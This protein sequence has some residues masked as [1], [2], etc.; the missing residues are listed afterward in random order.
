LSRIES[1]QKENKVMSSNAVS[2][3]SQH[4]PASQ[5]RS[6][7]A[8]SISQES[9]GS[10]YVPLVGRVLFSAL[11]LMA[12]PGHFTRQEIG[13]AA[14]QHV[15]LA[16]LLVPFSGLL[17]AAGGLSILLGYRARFGAWL[18]VAFL[19]PVTLAMH[20]FWGVSDPQ[21]AQMQMVMFM[22]NMAVLG[23]A[24]FIAYFGAGP[25]SLD[26]RRSQR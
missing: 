19:V 4:S 9:G 23:G 15:P 6:A 2:P 5:G 7:I 21:M 24:L 22:K 20:R 18:L 26:A 12:A 10:R 25:L 8:A 3:L 14:V 1:A 16:N 11:F 17:A 13:Y